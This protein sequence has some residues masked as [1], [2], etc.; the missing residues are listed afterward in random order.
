M[1]KARDLA[2]GNPAPSTVST[3][4][5]GYVDGVTSAI[6]TQINNKLDTSTA[7]STYLTSATAGTT[8]QT[9]ATTGLVLLNTTSFSAVASQSFTSVFNSTYRNYLIVGSMKCSSDTDLSFRLRSGSTDLSTAN[10][11]WYG[12]YYVGNTSSQ[13]FASINA[14]NPTNVFI[15]AVGDW[16]GT[17]T[18]N[19]TAPFITEVTSIVGQSGMRWLHNVAGSTNNNT[20][21]YDGFSLI[22]SA[23]NITGVVNVYGYNA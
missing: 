21:S 20:T 18:L 9:K 12:A 7:S 2:S 8:Y 1:T 19:I 22:P 10:S 11:Y 15:G 6:Q 16:N 13:A 5:L 17:L 3:T 4:E 14:S 23:G